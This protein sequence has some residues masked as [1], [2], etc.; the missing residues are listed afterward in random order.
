MNYLGD[1]Y[2]YRANEKGHEIQDGQNVFLP[3]FE[4]LIHWIK[5]S[6]LIQGE[7]QGS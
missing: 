5:W 3:A 7:W 1:P 4:H 6:Q 2:I